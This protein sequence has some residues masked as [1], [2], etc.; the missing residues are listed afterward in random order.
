MLHPKLLS[1]DNGRR[2][3]LPASSCV[4][5]QILR[6]SSG[7]GEGDRVETERVN[8]NCRRCSP[9]TDCMPRVFLFN[10][11]AFFHDQ[12]PVRSVG[13]L[14]FCWNSRDLRLWD[15]LARRSHCSVA[16]VPTSG[17]L[18]SRGF[19]RGGRFI[20]I[21]SSA[22]P[23]RFPSYPYPS[24]SASAAKPGGLCSSLCPFLWR[25]RHVRHIFSHPKP[26]VPAL[27]QTVSH[28]WSL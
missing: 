27:N 12:T 3:C 24:F 16:S 21:H 10:P 7:N 28:C 8:A 15:T 5:S 20:S 22:C 11:P 23:A 14:V 26:L 19:N 1:V 25:K 18:I 13:F 9:L 4:Q 6:N 17:I 2:F